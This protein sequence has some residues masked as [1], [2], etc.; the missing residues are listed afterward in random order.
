MERAEERVALG[1]HFSDLLL[2]DAHGQV[3][4]PD[5]LLRREVHGPC[6]PRIHHAKP[7]RPSRGSLVCRGH[8]GR[9][10]LPGLLDFW[11]PRHCER[12]SFQHCV[13]S[14][15]ANR[16]RGRGRN[17]LCDRYAPARPVPLAAAAPLLHPQSFTLL[18]ALHGKQYQLCALEQH[19]H[20]YQYINEYPL[21][22][23]TWGDLHAHVISIF[24]QT[25]LIFLLIYVYK[26]W[27][28]LE[29]RGKWLVC[30]LVAISLGSMPLINTWDVLIYAPITVIVA[31]LIILRGWKQG[32]GRSLWG[33]LIAIPPL[34]ILIY[35]PF[36]LMLK[37]STG[38]IAIVK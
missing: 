14:V 28:S 2:F 4:Q 12:C 29:S 36:Y 33:Q 6:F 22:S 18:P 17:R 23:F 38:G 37:T 10:L 5:D 9:V 8:D 20:D 13:Q 7:G 16:S 19:P 25:I 26:Y 32:R 1:A 34:S 27:D 35:L 24:N 3:C 11:L 31:A 15:P 21:F 30:G